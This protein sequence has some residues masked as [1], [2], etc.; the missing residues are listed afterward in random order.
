MSLRKLGTA[1]PAPVEVEG[2]SEDLARTARKAWTED[3][4][5]QLAD[6]NEETE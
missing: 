2:A 5:R 3:D 4:E 6:E 1:E